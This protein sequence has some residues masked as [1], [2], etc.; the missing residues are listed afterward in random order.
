MLIIGNGSVINLLS[1]NLLN[2]PLSFNIVLMLKKLQRLSMP[3]PS[4]SR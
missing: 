2:H 3:A 1:H 4:A